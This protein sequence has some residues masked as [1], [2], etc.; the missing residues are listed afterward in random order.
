MRFQRRKLDCDL[1]KTRI[2]Q[3]L[4]YRIEH[5]HMHRIESN[6]EHGIE[7]NNASIIE[8]NQIISVMFTIL[9]DSS[10]YNY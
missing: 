1:F 4:V 3:Q 2:E 9:G 10:L 5:V 6:H 8:S 7:S